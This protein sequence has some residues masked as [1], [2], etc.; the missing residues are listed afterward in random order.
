M[1]VMAYAVIEIFTAQQED[2][3]IHLRKE[4]DYANPY[5]NQ[6]YITTNA[7]AANYL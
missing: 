7:Y 4:P 3:F 2:L 1:A 6:T 5:T